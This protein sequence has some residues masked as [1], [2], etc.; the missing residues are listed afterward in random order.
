MVQT[1][2]E[3]PSLKFFL[4]LPGDRVMIMNPPEDKEVAAKG[5]SVAISVFEAIGYVTAAEAF[6]VAIK[7]EAE[8][9][10]FVASNT[11]V[12]EHP[13][14]KLCLMVQAEGRD[15]SFFHGVTPIERD[16]DNKVT[17]VGEPK[18]I[19]SSSVDQMTPGG[20]FSGLYRARLDEGMP[21]EA[22]QAFRV[23][24]KRTF[25]IVP[26]GSFMTQ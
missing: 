1:S 24:A 7:E 8:A 12:R 11:P 13:D 16:T 4:L 18:W 3:E 10:A 21:N 9:D 6:Y 20:A 25:P 14:V 23:L 22:K 26:L 2:G 15:H 17:S 19:D 5:V